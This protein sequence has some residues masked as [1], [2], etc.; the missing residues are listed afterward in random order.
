MAVGCFLFFHFLGSDLGPDNGVGKKVRAQVKTLNL[1]N[2]KCDLLEVSEPAT[3][4]FKFL[5]RYMFNGFISFYDI[6]NFDFSKYDYLYVRRPILLLPKH[7]SFFRKYKKI[8]PNGKILYEIPTYPYDSEH[9]TPKGKFL[10][11]LDRI[12]RNKLY[13]VVDRIVTLSDDD[14]IFNTP[15]IKIK[16]GTDCSSILPIDSTRKFTLDVV[17]VIAVAQFGFWHGYD[18]FIKG[19]ADFYKNKDRNA[20]VVFHL[21]GTGAVLSEY[22][23]LVNKYSLEDFVIFHGALYGERLRDIFNICDLA[24]CSL[25]GHL[26]NMF[27]SSELKSREYLSVGI[28]VL[29]STKI[30]IIERDW[31][32]CMYI[33]ENDNPVN[34]QD[35]LVFCSGIY[36]DKTR[37]EVVHEIRAFAE[38]KCDMK[39]TMKPIVDFINS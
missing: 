38:E 37:Q 23:E 31:K 33:E 15:T 17:H 20:K 30:D 8:K 27:L 7:I 35:M 1:Y 16:N 36:K 18:R 12:Y 24:V 25:G 6:R 39:V 28:P 26:K 11:I 19:L 21:V 32:Y 10:L 22:K 3:S 5:L 9:K 13:S 14:V 29:A 34:I 4:N 2:N